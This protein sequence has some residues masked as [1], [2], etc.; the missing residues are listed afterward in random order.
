MLREAFVFMM[1]HYLHGEFP[2]EQLSP[3]MAKWQDKVV[4]ERGR[5]LAEEVSAKLNEAG[6]TTWL[7]RG[8]PEILNQKLDR[9]Y[10][11]VDVLG[12]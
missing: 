6:W 11:D 7:E 9:D 3:L 12:R 8:L 4:G 10:G 1:D 2:R 5:K